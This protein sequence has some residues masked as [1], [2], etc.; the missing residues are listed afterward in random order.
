MKGA[1]D[2]KETSILVVQ[3]SNFNFSL[4]YIL[5]TLR[6]RLKDF[7]VKL[8]RMDVIFK[9]GKLYLQGVKFGKRTW[10]KIWMV[11]FKPSPTGVGRVEL[12][13]G[14]TTNAATDGRKVGRQK[15]SERKVVRL[16]DCLSV[17]PTANESCP[18][19]CTAFYLHTI[20][21]TYTLASPASQDWLSALCS[22]AFQKDPGEPHKGAFE[23]GDGLTMEENDLYSSWKPGRT[24]PP[25]Q[26]Q[27]TVQ[28]TEASRRCKLAGEYLVSPE[29]EAVRLLDIN[30]GHIF[31]RW[32]YNFLRKFGLVEGGFRIEAGRRCESGEGVFIFLS[33]DGP[34]IVQLISKQCSVQRRCSI[35]PLDV[36]RRSV[37]DLSTVIL[38]TATYKPAAPLVYSPADVSDD[39]EDKSAD[40][41]STINAR[42]VLNVKQLSLSEAS[43]PAAEEGEEE[44][45]RCQSLPAGSL[46][47]VTEKTIYYNL[48]RTCHPLIRKDDFQPGTDSECVYSDLKPVYYPSNSQP[49]SFS[50]RPVAQPPPFTLSQSAPGSPVMPQY[51]RRSPVNSHIQPGYNAQ[52][53]A[54]D[55]MK[56]MEEAISYSTHVT[57]KEAHGSFKRRLAEI[58][59][60]DLAKFQPPLPS[61]AGSPTFY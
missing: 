22:L 30:T 56:E 48:T 8:T 32:P 41:Y 13:A 26:Y 37:C 9:E 23:R 21:C 55:D 34:Q 24:L 7:P 28:S 50:P 46:D 10:R 39:T 6:T 49:R 16:S 11:L 43:L 47:D 2:V 1:G 14:P 59:S 45:E 60:K 33:R 51:Q 19:G 29:D 44:G 3:K 27:V 25:N 20:Q 42:P 57:P 40:H 15:S 58:L 18:P 31:Y 61:G 52:A 4:S 35:P 12:C 54:L 5:T 53:Q 36:H 17:D 38:P